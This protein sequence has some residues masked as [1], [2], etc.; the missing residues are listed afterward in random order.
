MVQYRKGYEPQHN[1]PA[2]EAGPPEETP[3]A[4][5]APIPPAPEP[6]P[7]APDERSALLARIR[8]LET[9][10]QMAAARARATL[11]PDQMLE[12]MP[13][14]SQVKRDWLRQHPHYLQ[15]GGGRL[16]AA[17]DH[18]QALKIE[19]DS[20]AYFD[21]MNAAMNPEPRPFTPDREAEPV[22]VK[23]FMPIREERLSAEEAARFQGLPQEQPEARTL[24]RPE[25]RQSPSHVISAPVHRESISLSEGKPMSTSKVVLTAEQRDIAR[26]SMPHL[27]GEEA[28]RLYAQGVKRLAAAKANG[29]YTTDR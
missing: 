7:V 5:A 18:S 17:H 15:D 14:L 20:P 10:E 11:T 21:H 13:G 24:P 16:M 12:Q 19:D 4:A 28:E 25:R 2:P 9:A 8:E 3:K 22:R 27:S 23:D 6:I 26:K 29:M 1:K